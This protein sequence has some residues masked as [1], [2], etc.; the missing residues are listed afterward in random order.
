MIAEDGSVIHELRFRH[1]VE[2]VWNAIVDRD[3]LAAWLMPNDFEPRVGHEFHFDAGPPRGHIG[4]EVLE[5]DPPH[6]IRWRWTIDGVPTIVTITLRAD[7]E[8]TVL[9][10]EHTGLPPGPR[11][12]FESGWPDKLRDLASWLRGGA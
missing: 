4:A 8:G 10:L 6:H 1:P 11:P 12:D 5:L 7:G 3:A 9:H 2:R